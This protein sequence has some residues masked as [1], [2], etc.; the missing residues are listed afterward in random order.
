M[1]VTKVYRVGLGRTASGRI[2]DKETRWYT[3][4]V[5]AFKE[6]KRLNKPIYVSYNH[7]KYIK[8]N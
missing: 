5:L 7:K 3:D 6:A 8:I 4:A 1:G 2:L